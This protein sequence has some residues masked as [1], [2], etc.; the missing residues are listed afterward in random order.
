MYEKGTPKRIKLLITIVDRGKGKKL[1]EL[2]NEDNVRY[3]IIALGKGTANSE[4]LD[5]LG[6]GEIE[7]D[8]VLS[9]VHEE[10]I[11]NIFKKLQEKMYLSKPGNGIAFTIPITSIDSNNS[12]EYLFKL[13]NKEREWKYGSWKKI[14]FNFDCCK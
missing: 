4:I 2:F 1:T 9:I 3:N 5:Y 12:L 8:I 14:W 10:D 13:V 6:L 11:K 7:K